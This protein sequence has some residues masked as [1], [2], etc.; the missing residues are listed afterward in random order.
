MAHNNN[1]ASAV[2]ATSAA[3]LSLR[4]RPP[5]TTQRRHP[6][7]KSASLELNSLPVSLAK[8]LT[9]SQPLLTRISPTSLPGKTRA[10]VNRARSGA[11]PQ[12]SSYDSILSSSFKR[13]NIRQLASSLIR[14]RLSQADPRTLGKLKTLYRRHRNP[15]RALC[16]FQ[17]R[18]SLWRST[19][20]SA[21]IMNSTEFL[22]RIQ[23]D[24]SSSDE[25]A[26]LVLTAANTLSS[27]AVVA[28]GRPDC[29]IE[30]AGPEKKQTPAVAA[31]D[32]TQRGTKTQNPDRLASTQRRKA[33]VPTFQPDSLD[34]AM[35]EPY[36]AA[37]TQPNQGKKLQKRAADDSEAKEEGEQRRVAKVVKREPS[38]PASRSSGEVETAQKQPREVLTEPANAA[39]AQPIRGKKPQKRASDDEIEPDVDQR[40]A[41]KVAKREHGHQANHVSGQVEAAQKQ[42]SAD[43]ESSKAGPTTPAPHKPVDLM[44]YH[45]L[46][47]YEMLTD[48]LGF[49]DCVYP[50]TNKQSPRHMSKKFA[51]QR[52]L[53]NQ[54]SRPLEMSGA[55]GPGGKQPARNGKANNNLAKQAQKRAHEQKVTEQ[56]QGL[57]RKAGASA[58]TAGM[59]KGKGKAPEMTGSRQGDVK[60]QGG[61]HHPPR[62]KH[63]S[64][65]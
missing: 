35:T 12:I 29:G 15:E 61:Q 63:Y 17:R 34:K 36:N 65:S 47:V 33:K 14:H 51:R 58:E 6:L 21:L 32:S 5:Q 24:E 38:N 53:Q 43:A 30:S 48:P 55:L 62:A 54:P 44:E 64:M 16:L 40:R 60:Q 28:A 45:E 4:N 42:P 26:G 49:D 37:L 25:E 41:I 8:S 20:R 3:S 22:R 56:V 39:L 46:R 18:R 59:D 52:G 11:A 1:S 27:S 7:Q 23:A 31:G 50:A 10:R 57:K 9:P 19:R 2:R 13:A